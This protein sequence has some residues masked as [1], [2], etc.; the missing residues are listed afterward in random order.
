[1]SRQEVRACRGA[2]RTGQGPEAE[3]DQYCTHRNAVGTG[4]LGLP[5]HLCREP[6]F[7]H[8][9]WL[10]FTTLASPAPAPGFRIS[11]KTLSWG[12]VARLSCPPSPAE[13][14]QRDPQRLPGLTPPPAGEEPLSSGE[15][16]WAP[17]GGGVPGCALV[18][19]WLLGTKTSAPTP[20]GLA[21]PR[22][23]AVGHRL[24]EQAPSL[25]SVHIGLSIPVTR[26]SVGP[27]FLLCQG[28]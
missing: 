19:R 14:D 26:L 8:A 10:E 6:P 3:G 20:G 23:G 18:S 17:A 28:N 22:R 4:G 27:Q 12:L 2:P 1:M 9:A 16:L 24:P 15:Q 25:P 13:G 11:A 21:R 7:L 5:L